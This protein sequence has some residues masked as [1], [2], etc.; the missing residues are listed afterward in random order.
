MTTKT[1]K[2][3]AI[4]NEENQQNVDVFTMTKVQKYILTQRAENT[5]VKMTE[6]ELNV[7]RS[8]FL[9]T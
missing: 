3:R 9:V 1:R 7:W 2:I 8:F 5:D 4:N 6:Y